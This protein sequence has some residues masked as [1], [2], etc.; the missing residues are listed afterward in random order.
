MAYLD[1]SLSLSGSLSQIITITTEFEM[2]VQKLKLKGVRGY[3]GFLLIVCISMLTACD[4]RSQN[5][6]TATTYPFPTNSSMRLEQD[7]YADPSITALDA[8]KKSESAIVYGTVTAVEPVLDLFHRVEKNDEWVHLTECDA[9]TISAAL[10][11]RLR[12]E[13]ASWDIEKDEE[14]VLGLYLGALRGTFPILNKEGQLTW[15]DHGDYFAEGAVLGTAGNF[16][17]E[18]VFIPYYPFFVVD[19]KGYLDVPGHTGSYLRFEEY[20][21]SELTE[22]LH[23]T[24]AEALRRVND[25]MGPLYSECIKPEEVP[26]KNDSNPVNCSLPE[27][28]DVLPCGGFPE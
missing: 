12:L 27:N 8:L 15:S 5:E 16:N 4:A 22:A 2:N 28:A 7:I 3:I 19:E 9:D 14:I 18:G 13:S 21:L 25:R 20:R 1:W 10:R 11:V 24:R 26:P 23:S 17:S 6:R